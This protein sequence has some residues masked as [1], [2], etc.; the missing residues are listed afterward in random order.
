MPGKVTLIGPT[1]RRV[2]ALAEDEALLRKLGYRTESAQET[3]GRAAEEGRERAYS[4]PIEKVNTA[5]EGGLSALTLGGSDYL[6]DSPDARARAQYNPGIRLASEIVTGIGGS[7]LGVGLPGLLTKGGTRVAASLGGGR[8]ATG[9]G[10]GLEGAVQGGTQ[11]A[12]SAHL[13]GD[14]FTGEAVVSGAG[15]GLLLGFGGGVLGGTV[16]RAG[17]K[18]AQ[19]IE[20]DLAR[21]FDGPAGSAGGDLSEFRAAQRSHDAVRAQRIENRLAAIEDVRMASGGA[22]AVRKESWSAFRAV[23]DEVRDDLDKMYKGAEG[24]L[25]QLKAT[26]ANYRAASREIKDS[27]ASFPK[28]VQGG[29]VTDAKELSRMAR[30]TDD[31]FQAALRGA[32]GDG[33]LAAARVAAKNFNTGLEAYEKAYS[34]V[35]T[36]G[37]AVMRV[38]GAMAALDAVELAR[39]AK[40]AS[41]ALGHLPSDAA[42]LG[43]L[44]ESRAESLGAAIDLVR[45][46]GDG[47]PVSAS[48]LAG[49]VEEL[50]NKVGVK[51]T[52]NGDGA[53]FADLLHQMRAARP[54][55]AKFQAEELRLRRELDDIR[56]KK[57]PER[58]VRPTEPRT[59]AEPKERARGHG[60]LNNVL[61]RAVRFAG[62]RASSKALGG[63]IATYAMGS[64]AAAAMLGAVTGHETE[65][66]AAAGILGLR[67]RVGARLRGALARH[68][69]RIGT[70]IERS[71]VSLPAVLED[72]ALSDNPRSAKGL[73]QL[74][75]ARVEEIGRIAPTI[76]DT[77][78]AATAKLADQH[79]ELADVARETMVRAVQYLAEMM[80]K[81][82]G[83]VIVA[84]RDVW[85]PSSVQARD[86]GERYHAVMNPLDI[87]DDF[88]TGGVT[89]VAVHAFAAVYPALYGEVVDEAQR[90][91]PSA[92][93]DMDRAER[94]KFSWLTG[95]Q[96]DGSQ[97]PEFTSFLQSQLAAAPTSGPGGVP[98]PGTS[99]GPGR[100]GGVSPD[101]PELTAAQ[102][103][104]EA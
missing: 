104:T 72:N 47:A 81:N 77:A 46:M 85:E 34:T 101:S 44:S 2:E 4:S 23:T 27:I 70:T 24:A 87:V 98:P 84:G 60:F 6:L 66:L 71:A 57:I 59:A 14:P 56:S 55:T 22:T 95:I 64:A 8:L 19:R 50:S 3:V 45:R 51:L 11:A 68:G 94:A 103:L 39:R 15:L 82:P 1:G 16:R 58:D 30:R 54:P 26:G 61:H 40:A 102:R 97:T 79:P 90:M 76:E 18:A 13:R 74:T 96:T 37:P 67:G 7:V 63:G 42:G 80:P 43:A 17:T 12:A 75:L 38:P 62:G 20:D 35:I 99:P 88:L 78:Y 9:L 100:P 83:T 49:A 32:E 25:D 69:G 91:L 10:V 53:K 86:F 41:E 29:A 21:S 89:P 36:K 48:R 73:R 65:G 31:A 93:P 5:F 92:L 28:S 52:S 33:T